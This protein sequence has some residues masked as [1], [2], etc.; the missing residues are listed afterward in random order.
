MIPFATIAL[1]PHGWEFRCPAARLSED[2]PIAADDCQCL[3]G[4]AER[5]LQVVRKN[6]P[7]DALLELGQEMCDWLNGCC[8]FLT[9]ALEAAAAPLAI[10]FTVGRQDSET[11]LA[12]AL[13][14]APWEILASGGEHLALN[15]TVV[16]CPIRRIGKAV[17][18]LEPSP[19]RLSLV[20]M[21]AAPRGADNLDYEGEEASI[22]NATRNIR[23]DLAVEESGTIDLLSACVALQK[24]DVIQI[25]CHGTL[26]PRPGLL[27]ED[28]I[29]NA[30]FIDA[31]KLVT[32]LAGAHPRLLFLSACETAQADPV[33][34][35]LA[36]SLVLAGTP[37]VLGW[38]APVLDAEATLFA[39]ALYQR[40]TAGADLVEAIAY[41][42]LE[43]ANAEQLGPDGSRDWHLTRLF[44]APGGGGAVATAGGP[45][46]HL[47]QGQAAKT[48]LDAKGKQI[49]VASELEFVGRR[50]EIQAIL[51]EFRRPAERR[52]G[53]FIHGVGRQGKSSL[54][55]RVAHRLE[56]THEIVVVFGR[57]DAP[58]ILRTLAER[59][60]TPAVTD[61][62]ARHLPLVETDHSRLRTTLREIL[63]GPCAQ[64]GG[65][66]AK[67]ILLVIDDFER[68]LQEQDHRTLKPENFE[69]IRALL[70]AF[71]PAATES[72]LLFTSRFQ[73]TCPHDARDLADGDH[74]FHVPLRGMNER[75]ARKQASA[76]LRAPEVAR[77]WARLSEKDRGV[78]RRQI[79]RIIATARGNPGLQDLLFTLAIQD[80]SACDRCLAQME[81]FLRSGT[82]PADDKIRA[83]LENLALQTLIGLLS[84]TQRE[85]LRAST[86]FQLPVPAVVLAKVAQA[87]AP[88]VTPSAS[89]THISRLLALGLWE[90]HEDLHDSQTPAL[91]LNELVRPLAGTL[92][93]AEQ[94]GL[95]RA[96]TGTL[97]EHWGG[98][99]S[100]KQRSSVQDHELTR[101][102]LLA[103][104]ARVLAATGPGAL[105]YLAGKFEYQPAA[106]WAKRILAI[107]DAAGFSASVRLLR[108][109]AELCQQIGGVA[110]ASVFR[111]RAMK[112]I[113]QGGELDAIQNA[114]T[115]TAH[116]RAL[117]QQG[118]SDEALAHLE[119]AKKLLPPG[120]QQAIVSGEI[121][122]VLAAK[123]EVDAA[124]RLHQERLAIF[125]ALGDK[126]E[127]A[128]TLGDIA[129]IWRVKGEVDTALL[130]HQER[131]AI[132]EA[133]GD[134]RSRAVTLGDIARI[135]AAK[136]E[137]DAALRLH[138]ERLAIFEALGDKRSRAVTLGDIARI[139]A[140]K[141]EVDAAL[142]LH[143]EEIAIYEALGDKRSRAVTLGDIA[144]I[145]KG[146]GEV[147][148]A[149][150]LLNERLT[151]SRE[152]GDLDG[153][154]AASF[155]L[156][157]I[158]IQR[159]QGQEASE[160][161][162]EA[163]TIFQKMGHLDC[164]CIVGLPLGQLLYRTGQRE[165][166]LEILKRSRDGFQKLGQTQNAQETQ[167][168][169]DAI[170][171]QS[172]PPA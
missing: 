103:Q 88:A 50:R 158:E 65:H 99:T 64:A 63:E 128:V 72:H 95:A 96:V 86:L 98:E 115:L 56:S 49:P 14:N 151:V 57:Y 125:E 110:D 172:P 117:E 69:S 161:W 143:Q 144:R 27:L 111:E 168:L 68:A 160:H 25:S 79:E 40:L 152:L 82:L 9:R 134:K 94:A 106:D 16:F 85:L 42:R 109:A 38:A 55:A 167:A 108:I 81:E 130:L 131:L 104:D 84:S 75:E 87:S 52:A 61:M 2:R 139:Q 119:Q 148:A 155:D 22:I 5:F 132:F 1:A 149:L 26:Q 102:G 36:R 11:K 142:R 163:Y 116:A 137:V 18:P 92:S 120:G 121:A 31:N 153:I 159:Q 129:R 126:W 34:P 141:G 147:D 35:S 170:S 28:D 169:I 29:G 70:L 60:S 127:R 83:F 138:Q 19:N 54:A 48:F 107:V 4:W 58:Y 74:L 17:A 105:R 136:G 156:G 154:A 46:R 133:L 101:L 164:I 7:G 89:E 146:K 123:G 67:P 73:F 90:V 71:G 44:L 157:G 12:R 32:R 59:V 93:G 20:F 6:N 8:S 62:V 30:D 112:L 150:S 113:T 15:P 162:S 10:E 47:R 37:A 53:V 77:E 43:L 3:E 24:P 165:Q 114:A 100:G 97:F 45:H 41:A 33:L 39:S 140:A 51:G 145:L 13:L 135:R 118:Q 66:G 23:L 122:K 80:P 78:L 166:G 21:A 124:L 171:S 91:A 76:K